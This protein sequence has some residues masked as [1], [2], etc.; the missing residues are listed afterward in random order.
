MRVRSLVAGVGVAL[1]VGSAS[2][3]PEPGRFPAQPFTPSQ[4]RTIPPPLSPGVPLTPALPV[5]PPGVVAPPTQ[6]A[7][8]PYPENVTPIDPGLLTARRTAT[9]WQVA[10]GTRVFRELGEDEAGAKEIVRVLREQR[11]TEWG[12]IGSGRPVVEYGLQGGKAPLLS[13]SP[14]T[15]T[16]IDLK[17]VRVDAVRGVWVVRDDAMIHLNCGLI[18]ADAEQATAAIRRYGFNRL[19]VIGANPAA[20]ALTLLFAALDGDGGAA[21]TVHPLAAAMQEQSLT[22]VGIPV[23]GVGYFGELVKI[24]PR[25]V[26]ARRDGAEWVVASGPEVLARFGPAE[27]TAREAARVIAEGRFT[28]FC[29]AG[30][31]TFFLVNGKAPTRVPFSTMGRRFDPAALRAGPY[32]NRW[33]VTENG[34]HLFDTADQ[35][36]AEG[37]VRLVRHFGF[38]TLC[39]VGAPPRAGISFMAKSR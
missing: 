13:G 37:L 10:L 26:D 12:V 21:P 24:E 15:V 28:E 4:P 31:Q 27:Y 39:Q 29:K 22:R 20:P 11:P 32:G 36:E 16:G 6:L 18:R 2:G 5:A 1:A 34:R 38:D 25:R 9:G 23:P 19:A 3:Q 30:G 33:A 14:R 7:A 8:L 17:T 35:A